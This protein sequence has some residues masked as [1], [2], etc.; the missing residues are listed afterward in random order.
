MPSIFI[1]LEAPTNLMLTYETKTSLTTRAQTLPPALVSGGRGYTTQSAQSSCLPCDSGP[2]SLGWRLYN[3]VSILNTH[4][5]SL[6]ERIRAPKHWGSGALSLNI[7]KQWITELTSVT[8]GRLCVWKCTAPW[9]GH[10]SVLQTSTD[11]SSSAAPR[12]GVYWVHSGQVIRHPST[13][14]SLHTPDN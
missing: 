3:L 11:R 14:C 7:N 6:T 9:L 12:Y 10:R 8:S 13:H 2:Y 5:L 1:S 4:W